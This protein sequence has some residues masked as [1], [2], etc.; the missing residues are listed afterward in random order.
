MKAHWRLV[1]IGASLCQAFRSS[2][3]Y[4]TN[5]CC[6]PD[7]NG[8]QKYILKMS[9]AESPVVVSSPHQ[10]Q[11]H[12]RRG[13]T[14]SN[15]SDALNTSSIGDIDSIN[16]IHVLKQKMKE[17]DLE[18]RKLKAKIEKLQSANINLVGSSSSLY[19]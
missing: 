7:I 9:H 3:S 15:H 13:S 14:N 17:V 16:D 4:A 5:S 1:P 8:D 2:Y 6:I 18:N 12:Q 19:S 10:Q 11:Q